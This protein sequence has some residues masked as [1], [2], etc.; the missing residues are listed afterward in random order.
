M[1]YAVVFVHG[2][3]KCGDLRFVEELL[4]K[5]LRFVEELR[6]CMLKQYPLLTFVVSK[7]VAVAVSR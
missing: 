5:K 7:L 1:Q 6:L 3:V 4:L 2:S